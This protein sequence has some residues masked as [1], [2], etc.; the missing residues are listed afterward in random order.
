MRLPGMTVRRWMIAVAVVALVFSGRRAYTHWSQCQWMADIAEGFEEGDITCVHSQRD[1][2]SLIL[3]ASRS[4]EAKRELAEQRARD[5]R[6][7]VTKCAALKRA[8]RRAAWR[9]WEP[10]PELDFR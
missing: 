10:M 7:R 9:P 3:D 4:A 6:A 8:F 1:W 5:D 2:D